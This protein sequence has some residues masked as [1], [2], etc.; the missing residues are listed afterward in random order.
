MKFDKD[1][2]T[3]QHDSCGTFAPKDILALALV[4]LK[5]YP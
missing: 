3:A 1:E 2:L 5:S 4:T